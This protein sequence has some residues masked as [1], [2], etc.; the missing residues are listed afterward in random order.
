MI[1]SG[2]QTAQ[3]SLPDHEGRLLTRVQVADFLQ[4]K[5][6]WLY[7]LMKARRLPPCLLSI[8]PDA[9]RAM[10]DLRCPLRSQGGSVAAGGSQ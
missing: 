2:P 4:V 5:L 10:P 9:P 8:D 3:G 6:R 7:E 1:E